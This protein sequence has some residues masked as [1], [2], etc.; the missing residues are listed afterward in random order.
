[1]S[2]DI[3]GHNAYG[4]K[5]RGVNERVLYFMG[6]MMESVG[7]AVNYG[8]GW[9]GKSSGTKNSHFTPQRSFASVKL[10]RMK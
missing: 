3:F 8:Q 5:I 7:D 10:P 6:V 2:D 1:M 4:N 9:V